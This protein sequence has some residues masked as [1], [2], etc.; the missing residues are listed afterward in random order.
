MT[1]RSR[2]MWRVVW[3]PNEEA[4]PQCSGKMPCV[5]VFCFVLA[6][7][8]LVFEGVWICFSCVTLRWLYRDSSDMSRPKHDTSNFVVPLRYHEIGAKV[9]PIAS[10][11]NAMGG[12]CKSLPLVA[13]VKSY[14]IRASTRIYPNNQRLF[15]LQGNILGNIFMSVLTVKVCVFVW[16]NIN[17]VDKSSLAF[18]CKVRNAWEVD[19]II[20]RHSSS[21]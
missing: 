5:A 15:S 19:K 8:T 7:K 21:L 12:Y 1:L 9:I 20:K 11:V 10:L 18:L 2:G 4:N 14:K 6:W 17:I 16:V 13:F 3:Y